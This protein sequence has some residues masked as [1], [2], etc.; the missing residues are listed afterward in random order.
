M[1][2]SFFIARFE[3]A[4]YMTDANK[5]SLRDIDLIVS[6]R[7]ATLE[8]RENLYTVLAHLGHTYTDYRLWLVEAAT[9]PRFDWQ[10]LR[11]PK[12]R[13]IFVAHQGAFPKS[14]LYNMGALMAQSPVVCFHDADSIAHPPSLRAA[15]DALLD[16]SASDVLCP[17]WSVVNVSGALKQRFMDHP[18]YDVF[19]AI[20]P[21]NLP[22]DVNLLS[23]NASGGI[24]LFRRAEY[25]RVGGYNPRITGWGGEDDELLL[26]ASRL[27]LRWHSLAPPLIHLHHDSDSRVALLQS[28]QET[29]N[30]RIP[31][32][33]SEMSQLEVEKLAH[34]LSRFFTH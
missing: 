21:Q 6:Y 7:E 34:E 1:P 23:S 18:D 22:E 25:I 16:G 5:I 33:M 11:D 15:V 8:R 26:R 29:D 27:G 12:I 2:K 28:I 14:M 17:Y 19:A 4:K 20:D 31:L 13:H 9:E 32:A 3:N 24:V 30:Y 10:R